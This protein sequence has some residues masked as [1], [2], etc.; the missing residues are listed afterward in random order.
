MLKKYIAC[1]LDEQQ[2]FNLLDRFL[3]KMSFYSIENYKS[4]TEDDLVKK[5]KEKII[6]YLDRN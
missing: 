5:L 2:P 3:N 1:I 6:S 4:M